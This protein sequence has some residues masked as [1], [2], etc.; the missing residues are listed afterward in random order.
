MMMMG[1]MRKKEMRGFVCSL[2]V[3]LCLCLW[4]CVSVCV[5]VSVSVFVCVCVYHLFIFL[6]NRINILVPV[7]RSEMAGRPFASEAEVDEAPS[8]GH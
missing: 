7:G 5:C 8:L 2:S 6:H 1:P 3:C 4:W